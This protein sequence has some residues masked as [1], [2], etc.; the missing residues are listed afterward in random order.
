VYK[1]VVAKPGTII[2][3]EVTTVSNKVTSYKK[4]NLITYLG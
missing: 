2:T 4:F 3:G 1:A